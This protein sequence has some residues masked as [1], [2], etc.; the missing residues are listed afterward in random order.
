MLTVE[1]DAAIGVKSIEHGSADPMV[2]CSASR[3]YR[4][5]SRAA[6][7]SW[8]GGSPDHSRPGAKASPMPACEGTSRS[9]QGWPSRNPIGA[10]SHSRA[11]MPF[12]HLRS[13]LGRARMMNP[14]VQSPRKRSVVY[15]QSGARCR[16]QQT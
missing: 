10:R 13:S 6:V 3:R 1:H 15:G 9:L 7:L 11:G 8:H 12:L 4:Q 14:V 2:R 5:S 16:R